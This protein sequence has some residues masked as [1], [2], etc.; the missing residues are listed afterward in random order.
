MPGVHGEMAVSGRKLF[1]LIRHIHFITC[2]KS[3]APSRGDW[4]L[5][6]VCL[7]KNVGFSCKLFLRKEHPLF[8]HL[9][10]TSNLYTVWHHNIEVGNLN[11]SELL[12]IQH[13]IFHHFT[14]TIKQ[15][16]HN[17]YWCVGL[18]SKKWQVRLSS[19]QNSTTH[20]ET[21]MSFKLLYCMLAVPCMHTYKWKFC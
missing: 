17:M 1:W 3:W 4:H 10:G 2:P 14:M 15:Y 6:W 20:P 8:Q 9:T 11:C 18:E 12:S 7:I 21:N 16:F 19:Q 13:N 5:I